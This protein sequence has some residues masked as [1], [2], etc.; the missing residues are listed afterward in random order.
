MNPREYPMR[1]FNQIALGISLAASAAFCARAAD[2]SSVVPDSASNAPAPGHSDHGEAFNEGPRQA[3]HHMKNTGKIRFPVT[4]SSDE[5]QQFFVQGVGDLHGFWYFEAE[6]AFRQVAALDP[7]CAMAYWGMAMANINNT[8]RARDFIAKAV[9]LKE[10]A[11]DHE[12]LWIDS[13]ANY[14]R[15]DDKRNGDDRRRDYVRDLEKIVQDYPEDIEAKAFLVFQI[16]DNSQKSKQLP[17]S[18][19]QAVDAL[20][21]QIFAAEPMHPANHY[22]IHLWDGEKPI[23]A[24][25]SAARNGQSAPGIA[26]MWHMPGHIFSKVYRYDDAAWQQ[27]AAQR[28][29]V[30]YMMNDRVLPDQIH[31]FAHNAEWLIR[32]LNH[33]GRV[34]D[35]VALAKNLIEM[36]RH[37][38]YNVLGDIESNGNYKSSHTSAQYGRTRLLETLL[39]WEEWG[40]LRELCATP[41]LAPTEIVDEQ[42]R[43]LHALAVADFGLNDA[44]PAKKIVAQLEELKKTQSDERA[45]ALALAETRAK[46]EQSDAEKKKKDGDKIESL[47]ERTKKAKD[48]ARKGYDARI[49]SIESALAELEICAALADGKKDRAR[50]LLDGGKE[51]NSALKLETER[52]ARL[53]LEAGDTAKAEER[54]RQAVKSGKNQVL[55]LATLVYVLYRANKMDEA[56]EQFAALQQIADTADIGT[57]PLARLN[58]C[59]LQ[60]GLPQDWRNAPLERADSGKRPKI[61]K[62]GE[63]TWH[64][65]PAPPWRLPDGAQREIALSD[66]RGKPVIVIF[67]LG[68]GCAHCIQ[69]LNAFAPLA[70]DFARE[71]ISLVA[72]STDTQDGLAKTMALSKEQGG[73]PFPLVADPELKV[74]KKYRC[75]DDFEKM[76]LHGTF[77]V[78]AGGQVRWWDVSYKPFED[79]AFLLKEAKRLLQINGGGSGGNA[80]AAIPTEL[81]A[82]K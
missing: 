40:R 19:Y 75:Y 32:T 10:H 45:D 12:K 11:N 64:P 77:L 69:Q 73:F 41:Y 58:D 44:A 16:W 42:I 26:H 65:L 78:D 14:Y 63:L 23:R 70:S 57:P 8:Q 76:P 13:L 38:D 9:A 17:I 49:K 3:A 20:L 39:R 31:N 72:V 56:R 55:P 24:L 46:T 67:Y 66:Y 53:Y 2:T 82:A 62:L 27:E 68:H 7:Q 37:P 36:P 47:E 28:V 15:K 25:E 52:A 18:S 50:E 35:A 4:T 51:K 81:Q 1:L 22:R 48:A 29:D 60:L 71:G 30:T 74:F 80:Q 59:R 61:E 6:R 79:G 34:N 33:V 43:R 21:D 54:A 5:A